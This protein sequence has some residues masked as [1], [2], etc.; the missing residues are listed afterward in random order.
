[1]LIAKVNIWGQTPFVNLGSMAP[2]G[3]PIDVPFPPGTSAAFIAGIRELRDSVY[4]FQSTQ[5]VD[6]LSTALNKA[7]S[8][9]PFNPIT[10]ALVR[11]RIADLTGRSWNEHGDKQKAIAQFELAWEQAKI[12]LAAGE[13][14]L[15]L[16]ASVR[17]I[18]SLCMVKDIG[19]VI[20]Y[21]PKISPYAQKTLD[22]EP[23]NS[24][25]AIT[26]A[27]AKAYPPAVFGGNPK[28]A[29][30]EMA[31]LIRRRPGGFEKNELFDL[32]ACVGTAYVKLGDTAQASAWFDA[33]LELYPG[34][35]Y[36]RDEKGKL[37]Q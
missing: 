32:R 7:V 29:I 19:F 6:K 30:A 14:P 4:D 17:A 37:S 36:I 33:A 20:A 22:L 27:A 26:L 23:G 8:E 15:S 21:G 3:P 28:K 11:S 2:A 12:A 18:S 1:M 25:A 35:Q 13:T 5:T 34:N 16:M 9:Q 10:A 24:S 31:E